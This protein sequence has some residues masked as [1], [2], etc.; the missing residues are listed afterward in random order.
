M[1]FHSVRMLASRPTPVNFRGEKYKIQ[2]N[3]VHNYNSVQFTLKFLKTNEINNKGWS[4]SLGVK[5]G[6]TNP[7]CKY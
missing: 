4:S 7:H 1:K 5:Q 3:N 2:S 6:L